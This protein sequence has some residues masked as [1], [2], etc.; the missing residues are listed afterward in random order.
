MARENTFNSFEQRRYEKDYFEYIE[1]KAVYQIDVSYKEYQEW[2]IA[3]H[4]EKNPNLTLLQF[5]VRTRP[6][7]KEIWAER[8]KYKKALEVA[9]EKKFGNNG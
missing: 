4:K 6:E 8:V 3:R 7:L 5:L 1:L 9:C 2:L